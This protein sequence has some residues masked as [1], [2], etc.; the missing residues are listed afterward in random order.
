M[1]I[2]VVATSAMAYWGRFNAANPV[3]LPVAGAFQPAGGRQWLVRFWELEGKYVG[4]AFP[5]GFPLVTAISGLPLLGQFRYYSHNTLS[6]WSQR[7]GK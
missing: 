2:T 1:P 6:L 3:T 4:I 7:F 5:Y